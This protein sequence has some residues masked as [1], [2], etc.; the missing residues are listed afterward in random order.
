VVEISAHVGWGGR[1]VGI[2]VHVSSCGEVKCKLMGGGCKIFAFINLQYDV[3]DLRT[4]FFCFSV[5][6]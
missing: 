5:L 4:G 2:S 3:N 1:E 6:P